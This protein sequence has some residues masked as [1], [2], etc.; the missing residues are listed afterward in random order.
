MLAE[1]SLPKSDAGQDG[2]GSPHDV[3]RSVVTGPVASDDEDAWFDERLAQAQAGSTQAFDDLVRWL[4]RPLLGFAAARGADDPNGTAND[5]LVRVFRAIGTFEGGRVQFRAWVFKI[6]RNVLLDEHRR[7]SR[8][9]QAD[10]TAPDALPDVVTLTD[11]LDRVGE[12]ERV[13]KMLS[14]LTDEQREVV[15]LRVVAGLSVEETAETVGRR[16]GAVRALQSRALTRLRTSMA[17][18]A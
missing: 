7:R 16:Q 4:E 15:L 17:R 12:R 9:P 2:R 18:R 10:P 3:E 14:S 11:E 13:E 1:P 5:V 6:T 8:R